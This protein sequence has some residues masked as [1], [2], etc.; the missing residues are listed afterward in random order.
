MKQEQTEDDLQS[1]PIKNHEL[2]INSGLP[3]IE[4]QKISTQKD[5]G[6]LLRQGCPDKENR[7]SKNE[8]SYF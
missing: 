8:V 3:A 7:D 5:R 2:E 4:P 6:F 1:I